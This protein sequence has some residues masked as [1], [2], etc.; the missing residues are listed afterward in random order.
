MANS[1][2]RSRSTLHCPCLSKSPRPI[3]PAEELTHT[4]SAED[5][6]KSHLGGTP[7]QAVQ[8]AGSSLQ[9][10]RDRDAAEELAAG[11]GADGHA[12]SAGAAINADWEFHNFCVSWRPSTQ[13]SASEK[14]SYPVCTG[15]P[16]NAVLSVPLDRVFFGVEGIS[17]S[18]LLATTISR[19]F[20]P[21][22]FNRWR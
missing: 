13:E 22:S 16:W 11:R 18:S 7:T 21:G 2:N 10:C 6:R 9:S 20:C 1:L 12:S 4:C 19:T 17:W 8:T 5:A 14:R 15:D 3:A